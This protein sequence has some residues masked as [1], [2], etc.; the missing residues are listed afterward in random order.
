MLKRELN[1]QNKPIQHKLNLQ[2]SRTIYACFKEKPY[3]K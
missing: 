3:K 2:N 1:A